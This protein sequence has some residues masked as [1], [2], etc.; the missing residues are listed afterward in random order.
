MKNEE[1]F[2]IEFYSVSSTNLNLERPDIAD[3]AVLHRNF[4]IRIFKII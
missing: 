2:T 1:K 3:W 4:R